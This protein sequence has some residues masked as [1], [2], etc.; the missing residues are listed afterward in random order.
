MGEI[1]RCGDWLL[2]FQFDVVKAL[3]RLLGFA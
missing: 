2:P 3:R 1:Q